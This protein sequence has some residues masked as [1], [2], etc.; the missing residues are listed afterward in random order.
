[1]S[2]DAFPPNMNALLVG[3][4]ERRADERCGDIIAQVDRAASDQDLRHLA[5]QVRRQFNLPRDAARDDRFLQVLEGALR[6]LAQRG[7]ALS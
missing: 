2:S 4:I 6:E 1:M 3:S 7:E 5:G